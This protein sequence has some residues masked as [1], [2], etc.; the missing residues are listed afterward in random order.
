MQKGYRSKFGQLHSWCG[1][2]QIDTYSADLEHCFDLF[3]CRRFEVLMSH[4]R[5]DTEGLDLEEVFSASHHH[6][7]KMQ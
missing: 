1:K 6:F 2:Q 4:G 5:I 7:L 3:V